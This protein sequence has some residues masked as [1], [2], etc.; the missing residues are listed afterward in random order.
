MRK[1]TVAVKFDGD[2]TQV[3]DYSLFEHVKGINVT[4]AL[5]V[6]L[7]NYNRREGEFKVMGDIRYLKVQRGWK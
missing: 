5:V 4:G 6:A 1:F 7:S 2:G 3:G